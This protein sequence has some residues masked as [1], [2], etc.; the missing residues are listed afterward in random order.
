MYYFGIGV[1][2][3]KSDAEHWFERGSKLH[4]IP[5]KHDLALL[6]FSQSERPS[7]DRAIRLLREASAGGSVAA[8]HQL[9]LELIHAPELSRSSSE[10]IKLLEEAALDGYWK[11]SAALGVL[12]RDGKGVAIDRNAA[13]YHFRI[14]VLEGGEKAA[15]TLSSDLRTLSSELDAAQIHELDQRAN[16]WVRK[17]NRSLAFVNLHNDYANSFPAFALAQPQNDTHAA[18]LLESLDTDATP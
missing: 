1:T 3:S 9:G 17:H 2:Q 5:A 6:L 12:S 11:S 7:R 15:T 13:Y 10:A 4:N 16:D 18:L 8:K 14:A